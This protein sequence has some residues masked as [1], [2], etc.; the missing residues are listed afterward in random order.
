M[1][2]LL[3]LLSHYTPLPRDRF[4]D[5]YLWQCLGFLILFVRAR[6]MWLLALIPVV[7]LFALCELARVERIWAVL[8]I[9]AGGLTLLWG[10]RYIGFTIGRIHIVFA[11]WLACVARIYLGYARSHD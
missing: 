11:A 5:L 8:A 7:N 9:L 10:D 2:V 3:P 6:E 4:L 1:D